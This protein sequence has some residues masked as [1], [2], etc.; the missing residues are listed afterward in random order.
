M[1]K[2]ELERYFCRRIP[3]TP[4]IRPDALFTIVGRYSDGE[5][6]TKWK[7]SAWCP[8]NDRWTGRRRFLSSLGRLCQRIWLPV[9]SR[10]RSA[11][12]GKWRITALS[13]SRPSHGRILAEQPNSR[14]TEWY[15][16]CYQRSAYLRQEY[17]PG[18][19][20][21]RSTRNMGRT[22]GN[23]ESLTGPQLCFRH[24]PPFLPCICP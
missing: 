3:E 19:R 20:F 4:W 24:Q 13:E 9:L 22:S 2:P 10:M 5:C 1:R 8:H 12:H 6:R 7:D 17:H 23:V 21:H 14:Q 15:A 16:G 18:R 11:Y